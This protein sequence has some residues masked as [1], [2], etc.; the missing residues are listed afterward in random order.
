MISKTA[1]A[2]GAVLAVA[3]TI[4][5]GYIYLEQIH[6]DTKE[7]ESEIVRLHQHILMKDS[8]RYAEVAKYYNDVRLERELTPAEQAR[9]DLVQKQQIRIAEQL[10]ETTG[11]Q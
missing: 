7:Q 9:F 1:G 8:A 11:A 5:S 3:G 10:L 6:I 2:I 4:L